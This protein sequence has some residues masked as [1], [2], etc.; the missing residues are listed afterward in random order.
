[1]YQDPAF[2][3]VACIRPLSQKTA[4]RYGA[5]YQSAFRHWDERAGVRRKPRRVLDTPADDALYFP[6]DLF[7][8]ANHHLVLAKGPE[9]VRLL[10]VQ[11]L[12]DYLDFTTELEALAVIPV[13]G[14]LGR[15]SAGLDLPEHMRADAFKIVTD[16]AWHA[17][18]S[19]DFARQVEERTGVPRIRTSPPAFIGRLEAIRAHLPSAVRGLESLMFTVVSE[20]LVSGILAGVPRDRRV[21]ESVRAVVRDH[22]E[23][24]GRHHVYFRTLLRYLWPTLDPVHRQAIGP[25]LPEI[26]FAFLE[27]DFARIG[28]ILRGCGFTVEETEQV[29]AESWPTERRVRDA[30]EAANATIRYFA[31]AG[32]LDEPG[33]AAAFETAGLVRGG[34]FA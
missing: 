23:D 17:Q 21:Q 29:L 16:E 1:M 19:D 24:E 34:G 28:R 13:A 3:D 31:D 27:P 8:A 25:V 12:Y 33:T 9:L 10:L 15:G 30:A 4:G 20:T 14:K 7:P 22:A 11:H 26:I 32:A 2:V 6:P 5:E 18:F